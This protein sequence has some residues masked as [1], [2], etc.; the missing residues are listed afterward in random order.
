MKC[1]DADA[2]SSATETR[3]LPW[4]SPGLHTSRRHLHRARTLLV[5]IATLMVISP[6]P[7]AGIHAVVIRVHTRIGNEGVCEDGLARLRLHLGPQ[8]AHSL[9][10]PLNPPQAR[11]PLVCPGATT[12]FAFASA[13]TSFSPLTSHYLRLAFLAGNHLGVVALP[14]GCQGHRGL[15]FTLPSRSWVLIC[16]PSLRSTSRSVASCSF[17]RF[18]PRK[19]RPRIPTFSA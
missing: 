9:P 17:A 11:G 2:A 10:P 8:I 18:T 4:Y 16:C 15:F 1:P 19:Y 6:S 7:Q 5:L 14:L 3:P 13:S 12:T